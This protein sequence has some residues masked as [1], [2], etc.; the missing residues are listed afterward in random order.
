MKQHHAN[1]DNGQRLSSNEYIL[2]CTG[3]RKCVECFS[4]ARLGPGLGGQHDGMLLHEKMAPPVLLL[5]LYCFFSACQNHAKHKVWRKKH[6][7]TYIHVCFAPL[8]TAPMSYQTVLGV[9]THHH[10][11]PRPTQRQKAKAQSRKDK[12]PHCIKKLL[13]KGHTQISTA[14][15]A[16]LSARNQTTTTAQRT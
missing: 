1:M 8:G 10:H 7:A 16:S 2:T 13:R 12:P 9:Q 6:C 11:H 14:I 5:C 4:C 15:P 3:C